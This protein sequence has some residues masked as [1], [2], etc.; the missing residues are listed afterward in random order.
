MSEEYA[1]GEL[2]RAFVTA[3]TH[4]DQPTRARA[5]RRIAKWRAVLA[6]MASG[7]L[8]V[9]IRSPVAG[10]PAWVTPEVVRGGFVTGEPAAARPEPGEFGR[11]L[12]EAGL[13]ELWTLLD[14]GHYR[15]ELPEDAALLTV[16]W[17]VA[18][19]DVTAALEL[20]DELT[21]FAER[22]RFTPVPAATQAPPPEIV[23]R[24]TAGS[25]RAALA[26]KRPNERVEA[27]RA[28][29]TGWNPMADA[30]LAFW[31]AEGPAERAA[32]L[33]DRYRELAAAH[34]PSSRH[35][36]GNLGILA[37]ATVQLVE[38][39]AVDARR[40]GAVRRAVR[41]MLAKRGAPG[42]AGHAEL[43]AR[44]AADAARPPHHLIAQVVAARVAELPPDTGLADP[45]PLAGPVRPGESAAVPAGT[46]VPPSVAR[47]L[48]R[49][50][51]G[52]VAE[53][54]ERGKVPSAEVLAGL[55]PRIVASTVAAAYPD[56]ALRRLV[57]ATVA[58]FG[59]R[60]SLLLT[61][62]S[63]QVRVEELPW[64]RAV[65]SRRGA[66]ARAAALDALVAL[67]GM[68]L[69]GFPET[70]LPNPMVAQLRLLATAAGRR[71]PWVDELAADIF[72]GTFSATFLAAAELA[73][74]LLAGTPYARYYGLDGQA[75]AAARRVGLRVT[76]NASVAVGFAELCS[77][78]AGVSAGPVAA[79]GAVIE[80]AQILTT[81]NL[82]VLAGPLGVVPG[83][84]WAEL[85]ARAFRAAARPAPGL[86]QRK[87]TAYAWRQGMFFLSL[88]TGAEQRALAESVGSAELSAVVA[89]AEPAPERR[90]LGWRPSGRTPA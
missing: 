20:V 2:A 77:S 41:D 3:L 36:T 5:E 39:G 34:P 69:T 44:Q 45:A 48:D 9:G 56:P 74:E 29:L 54:V 12:E 47:V 72:A 16:A 38:T 60:R 23:S 52:P 14:N 7:T 32:E 55:V 68:V 43:R 88:C 79:N 66:G 57:G 40:A 59:N 75:L 65:E 83:A 51:T 85:A 63:H 46:Q 19:G 58:A 18:H 25:V 42:S 62:L 90:R 50:V 81:H 27:E 28:V 17:L 53:L 76:A 70:I 82:A 26:G 21:P 31:L 64:M 22:L 71:L 61:D 35:R 13:R 24:E 1:R 37:E 30:F 89:G 80:Q 87:T 15:V 33:L 10:L 49:M 86:R 4:E 84:G 67:G 11:H 8:Q 6:G 78:R 73:H